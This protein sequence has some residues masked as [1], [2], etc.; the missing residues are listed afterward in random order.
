MAKFGVK[1]AILTYLSIFIGSMIAF[2]FLPFV[3]I[4]TLPEALL[5]A[6]VIAAVTMIIAY[7]FMRLIK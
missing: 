1:D 6:A 4:A 3:T 7:V 2:I 5:V